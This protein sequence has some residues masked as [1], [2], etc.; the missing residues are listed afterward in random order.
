P[1]PPAPPPMQPSDVGP[2]KPFKRRHDRRADL[3]RATRAANLWQPRAFSGELMDDLDR[4]IEEAAR[5][6]RK[7]V[8]QGRRAAVA[9]TGALLVIG[10]GGTIAMYQVFPDREEREFDAVRRENVARNGADPSAAAI[11]DSMA[12]E[13]SAQRRDQGG[14]RWRMMPGIGLGFA[15]AYLIR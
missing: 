3:L 7:R 6:A 12:S 8:W 10:V 11:A 5:L 15:A 14:A 1:H 2:T 4:E 9:S 13:L